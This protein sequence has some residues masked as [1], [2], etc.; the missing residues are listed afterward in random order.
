MDS[1]VLFFLC[2]EINAKASHRRYILLDFSVNRVLISCLNT[3]S[4]RDRFIFYIKALF[5]REGI[6]IPFETK[7][8]Y[9][10]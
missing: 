5:G 7:K 4:F 10:F 2:R 3:S 1:R 9:A 6:Y 8:K